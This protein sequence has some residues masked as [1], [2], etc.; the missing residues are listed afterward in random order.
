MVHSIS[1]T[2]VLEKVLLWHLGNSVKELLRGTIPL[3]RQQLVTGWGDTHAHARDEMSEGGPSEWGVWGE[4]CV[5]R[6]TERSRKTIRQQSFPGYLNGADSWSCSSILEL[7]C[8]AKCVEIGTVFC[9]P[10]LAT[11]VAHTVSSSKSVVFRLW[12]LVRDEN[13][14]QVMAD[15]L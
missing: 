6:G 5:G 12:L 9:C 14:A 7:T 10:L 11:P 4:E 1:V 3:E 8:Q 15:E 2:E 13:H